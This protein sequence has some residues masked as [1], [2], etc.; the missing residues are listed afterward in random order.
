M[1]R[2]QKGM[3]LAAALLLLVCFCLPASASIGFD[4]ET[5][6]ASV[7]VISAGNRLGSGFAIGENCVITNVHVVEESGSIT[8]RAYD[9]TQYRAEIFCQDASLDIAVLAV[10]GAS[11]TPLPCADINEAK[12]GDDIYTIGAPNSLSYTLTKGVISTKS[13]QVQGNDYIQIDAPINE[14]NSGG[15]LLNE[16][17]SVLGINTLKASDSEGIGFSIP[18]AKA[19]DLLEGAGIRLQEDGT[20]IG[21]LPAETDPTEPTAPTEDSSE[22]S[23][24]R[25]TDTPQPAPTEEKKNSLLP[26]LLIG[27]G[28]LLLILLAILLL[29]VRRRKS[30][31][32]LKPYDP[33]ERTDFEIE[34]E[35]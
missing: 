33:S 35:D 27:G 12:I 17:G 30:A 9:G 4:A 1:K 34:I 14:G 28:S 23:P 31:T 7:F 8:V 24:Q 29:L 18:I 3:A 21:T 22:P 11:F 25:P 16:Q 5:V 19:L 15:P 32:I 26:I 6:Y 20:V 13:R 10:S 2:L